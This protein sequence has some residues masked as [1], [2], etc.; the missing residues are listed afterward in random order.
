MQYFLAMDGGGS[1]TTA[2]L[3]DERHR[4]LARA[5]AGPSNPLKVGLS[6][7][8]KHLIGAARR[9]LRKLPSRHPLEVVCAGV[10]GAHHSS[11]HRK[12]LAALR[13]RVP[14]RRHLLTTDAA[15][16]L[17][18]ALGERPGVIVIS[19]TG[20][21]AYGRS[22]RGQ[23]LR[24]GG[25]G[26]LFSDEGSGYDL[27]RQAVVAALRD[28]DGRGPHTRL[29]H[30][31]PKA[32]G[33][34]TIGQ[35]VAASPAPHQISALFRVVLES[36]RRGDRVARR[37]CREAGKSL[38]GLALSLLKRLDPLRKALPV[39]C[40]GGVFHAS[41][42]VRRSFAFH[43]HREAPKS[44][45]RLLRRMPVEGALDLAWAARA[46]RP[47]GRAVLRSERHGDK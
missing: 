22:R 37:L 21:I 9:A 32:L 3:M 23:I 43:I 18:A 13:R 40:A 17:A 27:G 24:S 14:A 33:I 8:E 2:W 30:D 36:A 41:L 39:V 11:S 44:P 16:A 31:L 28:F 29:T 35:V 5:T 12:L 47:Q 38:A 26:S 20:S 34:R 15:I 46:T 19:G 1:K 7:S 4:I 25:W 45:V 10:A 42:S 6:K